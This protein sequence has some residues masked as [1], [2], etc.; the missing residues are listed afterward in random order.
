MKTYYM[1]IRDKYIN[2]VREGIKKHEYRLASPERTQIRIGDNIVLIS[3]QYKDV[4]VRTTVK[5]IT[6]YRDWKEALEKNWQS[7]FKDLY[8]TLDEAL[9]DCYK[10]YTKQ[11]VE[12]YGIISFDIEPCLLPF[13]WIQILSLKEKVS[14]TFL[15]RFP[16]SL[17]GLTKETLRGIFIVKA[18]KRSLYTEIHRHGMLFC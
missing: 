14:T 3:T 10:F 13:C 15:L 2:A 17:I 6:L 9:K 1:K 16:H 12:E 4:Y 8:T 18:K 11:E 7:D 5:G